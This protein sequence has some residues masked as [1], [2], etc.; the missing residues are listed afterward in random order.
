MVSI[1][2]SISL[3]VITAQREAFIGIVAEILKCWIVGKRNFKGANIRTQGFYVNALGGIE[4]DTQPLCVQKLR[5]EAN[6]QQGGRD[7]ATEKMFIFHLE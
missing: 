2:I 4:T 1:L 6:A 5:V 3:I 7:C